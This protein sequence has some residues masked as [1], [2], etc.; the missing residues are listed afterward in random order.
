MNCA[1]CGYGPLPRMD[2][3]RGF[4]CADASACE[5]RQEQALSFRAVQVSTDVINNSGL[6][7]PLP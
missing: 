6:M 1:L 3:A 5:Q 7:E 2:T 4:L